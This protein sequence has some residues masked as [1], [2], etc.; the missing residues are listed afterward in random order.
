[1]PRFVTSLG[2]F[3]AL[4]AS[5]FGANEVEVTAVRFNSV[6]PPGG[7]TSQWLEAAVAL[8]VHPSHGSPGQMVSNV[9]VAIVCAFESAGPGEKRTEFY[10]AEAECIALDAGRT[11]VRFYLPPELIKR[12]QL[13]PEPKQWGVEVM[14]GEKAL[15][16]S[17]AAYAGA[18]TAPEQRKS[19]MEKAQRGFSRNSGCLLPQ[20][21]TPFVNEYPRS[22]PSFVRR[23]AR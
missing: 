3:L 4:L 5:A 22:T 2:L 15:P 10:R 18:L 1:M 7:S 12:D 13:R 16:A 9:R 14:V 6:R 20:Y 21:L 8:A 23:E 11:D 19:F 17:R